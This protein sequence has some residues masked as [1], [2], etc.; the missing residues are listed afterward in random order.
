MALTIE[1]VSSKKQLKEFVKLPYRL[2]RGDPNW[3]PQLLM[4]D[5]KKLDREKH[6]FFMHAKAEIFLVRR[7][8]KPVGRIVAIDDELWEKC[9]GEK[10]AYWGWFESEDDP[11]IANILFDAAYSWSKQR[12]CARIIGPM[13]PNANDFV[14]LLV[15]GFEEPPCIMMAYNPPYY[16]GLVESCG[17]SKWKDLLAWLVDD[18]KIPERLEKIMPMVEKRGKFT[19]RQANMR[20]FK[21]EMKRARDI[22]N[23]FE[24]VNAIYTPF[25]EEEFDYVGNDLKIAIDP[26]IVFF[27]EVDGKPVGLSLSLPDMNVALKAAKGRLFPLGI[28]KILLASRKIARIRVL[29]MGVLKEYRNRGIDLAFY[30]YTY[31]NGVKKGFFSAELSWVEEDNVAMNNVAQKLNAKPYKTYRIYERRLY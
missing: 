28:F 27:A 13:T 11:A 23:E 12:G 2:Y 16:A 29:S 20:D 5:Y 24:K 18:P 31:K 9:Y 6:P 19:L 25:T 26:S 15:K 8:G 14:G 1:S 21:N 10:A 30:Y 7:E 22:Y 4:D 17:N 3:V